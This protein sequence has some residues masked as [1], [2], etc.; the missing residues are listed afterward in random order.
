[1]E[2]V[3]EFQMTKHGFAKFVNDLIPQQGAKLADSKKMK[4]FKHF[5]GL[6]PNGAKFNVGVRAATV[7][8]K[9]L[10]RFNNILHD[11][12][13]INPTK[14]M[15]EGKVFKFLKSNKVSSACV[16][17]SIII[18]GTTLTMALIDD[19][20]EFG[21]TTAVALVDIFACNMGMYLGGLIG[22]FICPGIGTTIGSLLGGL[23]AGLASAYT[24]GFFIGAFW[25]HVEEGPGCLPLDVELFTVEG[26]SLSLDTE[27]FR[28]GELELEEQEE[29]ANLDVNQLEGFL[30]Q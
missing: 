16:A 13:V 10:V 3:L 23:V 2:K 9:E 28:D 4:S 29:E 1:V 11:V 5:E 8:T 15:S 19:K 27:P 21:A 26:F 6:P 24:H 14:W 17:I 20:G 25:P 18:D 30:D 12:K 22:T 7:E